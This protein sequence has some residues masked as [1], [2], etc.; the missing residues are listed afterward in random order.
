MGQVARDLPIQVYLRQIIN[1][2]AALGNSSYFYK[3]KAFSILL[4]SLKSKYPKVY[5]LSIH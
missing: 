4:K 5:M 3:I 2:A 1:Q